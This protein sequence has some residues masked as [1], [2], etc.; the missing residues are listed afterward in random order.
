MHFSID[1]K[2]MHRAIHV[3]SVSAKLNTT[4]IPGRVLITASEEGVRFLASS[5]ESAVTI[6]IDN[7]K[8]EQP[9]KISVLYSTLRSFVNSFSPWDGEFGAKTFVFSLLDKS[10]KIDVDNFF[11]NGKK[12]KGFLKLSTFDTYT[13]PE[14]PPFK[15]ASFILNSSLIKTATN[16]V[17][18]AIDPKESRPN[19]QGM[20]V[21]FNEDLISFAGTDGLMLSEYKIKNISNMKEGSYIIGHS[22]IM[23]LRRLLSDEDQ[24]LFELDK[25]TIKAKFSNIC[26]WG[27]LII[28]QTY[29]EYAAELDKFSNEVVINK[30]ILLS[31]LKPFI[32]LLNKEDNSRLRIKLEDGQ[33]TLKNEHAEFVYDKALNSKEILNIDVNGTFML[34]TVDAIKDDELY[35]RFS[36][37]TGHLI[38]DSYNFKDQKALITPIKYRG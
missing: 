37:S 6:D 29:P 33:L 13:I 1:V 10:L 23:G 9:L 28:G 20:S 27:R 16:K 18:Y 34:N 32:G 3:L 14:P 35:L 15:Q 25:N 24:V 38:F 12:V 17:I 22:F 26:Y 31:C 2:D 8:V 21:R 11:P 36:D 7:A 5:V 19:L 30:E 4:D